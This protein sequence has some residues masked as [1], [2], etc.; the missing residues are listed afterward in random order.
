MLK[1]FAILAVSTTLF[2]LLML[3]TSW[4]DYEHLLIIS[5]PVALLLYH[6]L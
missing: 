3:I 2:Y 1:N 4:H 5:I 6:R